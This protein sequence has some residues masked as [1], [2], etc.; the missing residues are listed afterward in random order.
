MQGRNRVPH[1]G[2]PSGRV[3]APVRTPSREVDDLSVDPVLSQPL[4]GEIEAA[5]TAA[6]ARHGLDV[7]PDDG[8]LDP[9]VSLAASLIR[10]PLAWIGLF[11]RAEIRVPARIGCSL[12]RL[13]RTGATAAALPELRF[14]AGVPLVDRDGAC[15]GTLAIGDVV[16]R[17]DLSPVEHA[18]LTQLARLAMAEIEHWSDGRRRARA[19]QDR[20]VTD[21]LIGLIA[22]APTLPAALEHLAMELGGLAGAALAT[23]TRVAPDGH[24]SIC[25]AAWARP[26]IRATDRIDP[27][28]IGPAVRDRRAI[29]VESR[30]APLRLAADA[31]Q[32]GQICLPLPGSRL[33]L[34]FGFAEARADLHATADRLALICAPLGAVLGLRQRAAAL[35]SLPARAALLDASGRILLTNERWRAFA[36][37]I[38]SGQDA[39]AV[40]D[41]YPALR[42]RLA[43]ADAPDGGLAGALRAVLAGEAGSCAADYAID[44]GAGRRWFRLLAT[45]VSAERRDGAVVMHVEI[46][47]LKR[48]QQQLDAARQA[49]ESAQRAQAAFLANMSHELRTPLNAIIGFAQIMDAAVFGPIG[50]PR[51]RDYVADIQTSGHRL[52]AIIDDILDLSRIEADR[53]ALSEDRVELNALLDE[54]LRAVEPISRPRPIRVVPS[55]ATWSDLWLRVDRR[56]LRQAL[57]HLVINAV[58]FSEA[59]TPIE[60]RSHFDPERGIGIAILDHGCGMS[61]AEIEQALRPFRQNES[62]TR[63]PEEGIGLGLPL[64]NRMVAL[65]GGSLAIDSMPGVGTTVRVTLPS[66]RVERIPCA[67]HRRV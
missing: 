15:L 58:K 52:L 51:Y 39:G 17:A 42:D 29:V 26:G 54:V 47:E 49:A 3:C 16:P 37:D 7:F 66:D 1:G 25:V 32:M 59:G 35:D 45:P 67:L 61:A 53:Y 33:A 57:G 23:A 13:P 65:H 40:G 18:Q 46:T 43:V 34:S 38:P 63:R 44:A 21:R 27:T 10:A 22:A 20:A 62:L 50:N 28:L 24:E 30:T 41:A 8:R 55:S 4:A 11:G 12:R 19:D 2:L 31:G 60:V 5:R 6:W 48:S 36:R 9:V 56:A 14:H 64:A